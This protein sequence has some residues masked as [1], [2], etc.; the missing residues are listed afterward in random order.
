MRVDVAPVPAVEGAAVQQG[1]DAAERPLWERWRRARD[2]SARQELLDTHLPYARVVAASY[3]ARRMNDEVEFDDYL[4]LARVGLLEAMER[5]DLERGAAFR[6]YAARRM[7][8]SILN[9]LD[10][11]TEKQ[12]QIA[13]RRRLDAS[14]VADIKAVAA[15]TRAEPDH[16]DERLLRYVAE[17]GLGFALAWLLDGTAMVESQ[18]PTEVVPFYRSVEIRELTERVREL[19]HRLPEQERYVVH[20]HYLQQQP[21]KDVCAHMNLTKG[22]VSQIH[23]S[24][25]SRMRRWMCAPGELD[26]KV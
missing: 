11:L 5:F 14:R 12:R 16:D 22:R 23:R 7:H 3:Y 8:G 15:P 26:L 2:E 1:V 10:T 9:G 20:S 4:Q 13:T 17:V 18:E 21:F 19:I 25:L 6:T 24:A